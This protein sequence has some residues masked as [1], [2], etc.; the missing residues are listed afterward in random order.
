MILY[1]RKHDPDVVDPR[2]WLV[3]HL[4]GTLDVNH[5]LAASANTRSSYL[6]SQRPVIHPTRHL[7]L[8]GAAALLLARRGLRIA[9]ATFNH[10]RL[11]KVPSAE[12][13]HRGPRRSSGSVRQ[14][15]SAELG[16]STTE[17]KRV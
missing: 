12:C 11:S 9:A 13:D 8:V 5:L 2:V 4:S 16:A 1:A 15:P 3:E 17:L 7:A 14:R 10:G 6:C